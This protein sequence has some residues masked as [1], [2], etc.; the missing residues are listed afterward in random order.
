[1][2]HKFMVYYPN[3]KHYSKFKKKLQ[4]L[5]RKKYPQLK[6]SEPVWVQF[7]SSQCKNIPHNIIFNSLHIHLDPCYNRLTT[8][9]FFVV[10]PFCPA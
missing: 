5:T 6:K 7:T 1:M 4:K 8:L 3:Q 10:F 9:I 2:N